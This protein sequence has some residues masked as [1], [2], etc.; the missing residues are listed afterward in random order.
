MT[1]TASHIA[2]EIG[3][4]VAVIEHRC[5]QIF[6]AI[7]LDVVVLDMVVEVGIPGVPVHRVKQV[8]EQCVQKIV[9][10]R[11]HSIPVDMLMFHQSECAAVEQLHEP[12]HETM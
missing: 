4:A 3:D 8:R 10:R 1:A 6:S 2:K 12:M 9:F 7:A 11:Q 5:A